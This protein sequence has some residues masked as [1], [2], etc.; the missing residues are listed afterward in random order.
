MD[1]CS[2]PGLLAVEAALERIL[3]QLAPVQETETVAL[4]D[5]LD[6][7]LAQTVMAPINVPA[8]DN[9]AMDGYALR[10]ADC[11][12]ASAVTLRVIGQ[13]LAGHPYAGELCAGEAVR[14][15]TGGLL[16]VGADAV[17]MQENTLRVGDEVKIN[18][19]PVTGE[20]I[21]RA[22]E[23]ITLGTQLLPAGQ[24]VTGLDIGLLA[25][26][27]CASV[28]VLRKLR[29]ALLTTGD[30]L[31]LPGMAPQL[32]K[33]YDSNR[34]LL[35]ALLQRLPVELLDLGII[36]DDPHALR[37]AFT[38]A[39]QWADVVISTGGVSVG[40]ADYT[41]DVLAELGA[42]DFWKIAMK[43][44][45]P[46]AFGRL[47]EGW[48]FGL[49]GNPVSTAVTYHQLVVP[50]LRHLAGEQ[51]FAAA[52]IIAQAV[53]PLKKQPGRMDFQRGLL[54][55]E[56]GANRVIS[57]GSQSSG[58]LSSMAKANCYICLERERGSVA[59]GE[60]VNVMPFD[61]FIR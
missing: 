36:P 5:A 34:P 44:G 20:N 47:G 40:D 55:N 51:L 59:A 27:G 3:N 11:S 16:P 32:G 39:S 17:V 53:A 18:Q 41:K 56:Q 7:V 23:D 45:K 4:A 10:A 37:A 60:W 35:T 38:T 12:G 61:K 46:F 42:I 31:L 8:G 2:Q 19:P 9:S 26:V 25:S 13:S 28:N 22:G 6:R 14:I 29:I 54:T 21:R 48:F 24:F 49:P 43:P 58:V 1:Q 30:E 52:S 33:I 57:V 50:A 15:M